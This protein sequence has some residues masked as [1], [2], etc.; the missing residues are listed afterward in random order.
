M[1][2]NEALNHEL[3][4]RENAAR[5]RAAVAE[6]LRQ[7]A[8][9]KALKI[10]GELHSHSEQQTR[11]QVALEIWRTHIVHEETEGHPCGPLFTAAEA[12]LLDYLKGGEVIEPSEAQF[13]AMEAIFSFSE[14]MTEGELSTNELTEIISLAIEEGHEMLLIQL[15]MATQAVKAAHLGTVEEVK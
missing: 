11:V 9:A 1:R 14:A 4:A 5:E 15:S 6:G 12:V 2:Q 7:G 3:K 8:F 10:T 13:K